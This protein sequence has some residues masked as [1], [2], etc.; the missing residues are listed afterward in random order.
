M[1]NQIAV[2]VTTKHRGV[3]FGYIDPAFKDNVH[4]DLETCMCAIYWGTT[5]GFQELATTGPTEKSRVG[6]AA[7][8]CRVR[9]VTSVTTVS[10]EA[11][12]AWLARK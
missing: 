3:F 2:L 11:E 7:E 8:S 5:R 1:S 12:A 9:D 4:L 6:S 10:Q